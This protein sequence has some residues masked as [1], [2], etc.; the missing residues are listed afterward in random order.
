VSARPRVS[1]V[2]PVYNQG[3]YVSEAI[4]SVLAQSLAPAEVI[5][6]D[7]SD[8]GSTEVARSFVPRI[9]HVFHP[10]EGIGAA[11][12]LGAT[13]AT[14]DLLA[15]LD[16]DDVWLPDKLDAQL[17][18]LAA[19][20][21]IDLVGGEMEEFI[22]PDVAAEV[23]G[24]VRYLAA[25]QPGFSASVLLV[26]REAFERV[27]PYS[28]RW[29]LGADLDWFIR[30][31]EVGLRTA[32]VPR[33]LARRRLHTSNSGLRHREFARDR[34]HV[35]KLALDRRRAREAGGGKGSRG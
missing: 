3:A 35:L 31:R 24:K 26:R 4:E 10:R 34:V 11:R 27:G 5:V 29:C 6:V 30:A 33:V 19:D 7:S 2:I 22:S 15:H 8:D 17:A 28:T 9:R 12:N 18:V 14:G 21:G 16:A 23:G 1:V 25:P 32:T 13:L 20:P